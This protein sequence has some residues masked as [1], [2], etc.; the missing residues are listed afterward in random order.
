[1]YN[2]RVVE[3]PSVLAAIANWIVHF[4]YNHAR[5]IQD[6]GLY[7]VLKRGNPTWLFKRRTPRQFRRMGGLPILAGK[8]KHKLFWLVDQDK[9]KPEIFILGA[10][11][12]SLRCEITEIWFVGGLPCCYKVKPEDVKSWGGRGGRRIVPNLEGQNPP[13][14]KPTPG[15]ILCSLWVCTV[16]CNT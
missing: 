16:F 7:P 6:F 4:W 10:S 11:L 2:P 3:C 14:S 12:A 13:K 8:R 9:A 15:N 5:E 1:M